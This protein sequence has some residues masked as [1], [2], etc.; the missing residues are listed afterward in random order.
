SQNPRPRPQQRHRRLKRLR[1]AITRTPRSAPPPVPP[2]TTPPVAVATSFKTHLRHIF[3]RPPHHA[4]P[5]AVDV[6][7][8]QDLQRNAAGG[9]PRDVDDDLIRDEDHHGPPT[10]DPDLQQRQLA[11]VVQIDTGEHDRG[12]SCCCC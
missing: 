8:A 7:F 6:A 1:L 2:T 5:P 12:W 4:T 3:T 11:A 10:P 9:A